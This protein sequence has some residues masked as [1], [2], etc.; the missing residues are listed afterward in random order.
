VPLALPAEAYAVEHLRVLPVFRRHFHHHVILVELV[1]D[2]GHGALAERVVQYGV[3]LIGRKAVARSGGAIHVD[4]DLQAVLLQV[5]VDVG[6]LAALLAERI[7]QL[8]HPGE[9]CGRVVTGQRVLILRGGRAA[10]DVQILR[11][12]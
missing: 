10:A 2:G 9:Q 12:L 6:H 8:G 5:R 11:G 7:H 3:Q 4:V 1:V